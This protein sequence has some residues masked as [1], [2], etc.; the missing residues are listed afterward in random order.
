MSFQ[1]LFKLVKCWRTPDIVREIVPN[2]W[3]CNGERTPA[4]FQ[5]GARDKQSAMSS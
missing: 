2:S 3:G 5:T 1:A 4:D